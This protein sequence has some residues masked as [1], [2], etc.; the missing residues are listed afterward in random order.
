ML[1][2]RITTLNSI[3]EVAMSDTEIYVRRLVG[4][5]DMTPRLAAREGHWTQVVNVTYSPGYGML[6][7]WELIEGQDA[8]RCTRTSE[9]VAIEDISDEAIFEPG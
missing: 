4:I 1:I 3:Y 6:I 7:M 5:N 2:E 9:V 8:A